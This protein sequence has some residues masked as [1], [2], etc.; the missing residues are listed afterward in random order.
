MERGPR[1][2]ALIAIVALVA[3]GAWLAIG[4]EDDE[5]PDLAST[6]TA[7]R[8]EAR[9][10]GAEVGTDLGFSLLGSAGS[11]GRSLSFVRLPLRR[12]L[13]AVVSPLH[14]LV[15]GEAS[16]RELE[17]QIDSLGQL[18]T[19]YPDPG[20]RR[21]Y[22]LATQGG[23][24]L[25]SIG[26]AEYLP[27]DVDAAGVPLGEGF[28][29][30]PGPDAETVWLLTS[31]ERSARLVELSSGDEVLSVDLDAEGRPLDAAGSGLIVSTLDAPD[32]D[33]SFW[34]PTEGS[35]PFV[36][37]N[38]AVY[39]GAADRVA[40]FASGSEFLIAD[41]DDPANP[42]RRVPNREPAI[43]RT[44]V[45]PDGRLLAASVVT[46]IT[47]PN[48]IV[49]IDLADGSETHRIAS[50]IEALFQWSSPTRLI[51]LRPDWPAMDIAER[52]IVAGIDLNLVRLDDLTWWYS[53]Y[54]Q[55]TDP[56]ERG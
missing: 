49:I 54:E 46:G 22:L 51:Y 6:S 34:T 11:A 38:G 29:A 39:V 31:A 43:Y 52:D 42:P 16:A 30:L 50:S 3:V 18:S 23:T 12:G 33:F 10:P 48:R 32:A 24:V 2:V 44:S 8:A 35:R 37:T 45:S 47:E 5:G 27:F 28:A 9:S 21:E 41:L 4:P 53:A 13:S 7:P 56:G 55:P 40:V 14:T 25:T 17:I 26:Q 15:D 20:E 1:S 19:F 36:G